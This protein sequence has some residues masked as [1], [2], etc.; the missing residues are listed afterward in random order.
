MTSLI[1]KVLRKQTIPPPLPPD[2]GVGRLRWPGRAFPYGYVFIS[3]LVLGLGYLR[4]IDPR[5]AAIAQ[6]EDRLLENLTTA[7]LLLAALALLAV[8]ARRQ[9]WFPTRAFYLLAAAGCLFFAGEE[10]SWGQRLL[11]FATPD[12]FLGFNRQNEISF[13]NYRPAYE[14]IRPNTLFNALTLVFCL[15]VLAAYSNGKDRLFGFPLPS[16]PLV[17]GFLLTLGYGYGG[18]FGVILNSG[19]HTL[20]L[21]LFFYAGLARQGQMLWLVL[22]AIVNLEAALYVNFDLPSIIVNAVLDVGATHEATEV[23]LSAGLLAYSLELLGHAYN[24]RRQA[25]RGTDESPRRRS[26]G[27]AGGGFTKTAWLL[28]GLFIIVA[29]LSLAGLGYLKARME[30]A[31]AAA[32]WQSVVDGAAGEPFAKSEAGLEVYLSGNRLVYSWTGRDCR[33][34]ENQPL[35]FIHLTPT[36]PGDLPENR[37][38]Y[39]YENRDFAFE[40]RQQYRPERRRC[41]TAIALPD[42]PIAEIRTGQREVRLGRV[43]PRTGEYEAF[44]ERL[45]ESRL[46][47]DFSEYQAAYELAT[48][49]Q[50]ALRSNFDVYLDGNAVTYIKEPC[51]AA[52]TAGTFILHPF[53]VNPG[54]LPEWR[55]EHGFNN[56]DFQFDLWGAR[57]DGKCVAV[58]PLPGY[59]IDRLRVG[60]WLP[61]EDRQLWQGEFPVGR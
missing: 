27:W 59:P 31:Y 7:F 25:A 35:I 58:A 5:L 52:D 57:F 29:S 9:P 1:G 30:I 32:G 17:F 34:G 56:L 42:Y 14:F 2:S 22:A 3:L 18:A 28:A 16:V 10:I 21:L 60:Q 15:A 26:P 20:L 49:G 41:V 44:S 12:F 24:G 11:G 4:V 46:L 19:A 54:D 23:L 61:D 55:R 51:A 45:W 50:P 36:N 47:L 38:E 43:D 8:A 48:A 37:R 6:Q 13:H 39:G 53:P 40:G 33:E